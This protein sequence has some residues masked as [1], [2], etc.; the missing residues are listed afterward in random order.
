MQAQLSWQEQNQMRETN[1]LLI[2]PSCKLK[3]IYNIDD[4][5]NLAIQHY[6]KGD[7]DNALLLFN[8]AVK[9]GAGMHVYLHYCGALL[10]ACLA[11]V[12]DLA[13][14]IV[15]S[16]KAKEHAIFLDHWIPLQNVNLVDFISSA[17]PLKA[18]ISKNLDF[19]TQGSQHLI[20]DYNFTKIYADLLNTMQ[21][22]SPQDFLNKAIDI[23]RVASEQHF[24]Y[25]RECSK[26]YHNRALCFL[27][28]GQRELALNDITI[29]L[30]FDKNNP[31]NHLFR[32]LLSY[33][34]S[35]F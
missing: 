21:T 34:I 28:K 23:T 13:G 7:I 5:N 18:C 3:N 29:A 6:L 26:I 32:D 30:D 15:S 11:A 4:C 20:F 14:D 10:F 17:E 24:H 35:G 19:F 22:K 33:T 25:H 16:N 1:L 9:L 2:N 27:K 31:L 8:S 12:Y